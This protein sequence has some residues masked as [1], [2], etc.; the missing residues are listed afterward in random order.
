MTRL[1][2]PG[3]ALFSG[4]GLFFAQSTGDVQS[5]HQGNAI[6]SVVDKT[7][8]P[9]PVIPIVQWIFQQPPWVMWGG[10]VL[11]A[12]LAFFILRWFWRRRRN[13]LGWLATR[14][15]IAKLALAG[16]AAA[17]V[18]ALAG[19]GFKAYDFVENDNRFCN[20]CH[21]F[22]PSG[23]AWILPDTGH[24]TLVNRMEGK[25][26][27][28]SCHACHA[29][30]PTKE[31]VKLVFWMSGAR[32]EQIPPHAKVPREV[33]EDC[34]VQGDAKETW[35]QI[36]RT[37]GHRTHLESDSAALVGKVECL[38]CHA[39]SAHR[40]QPPDSTCAQDGCHLTGEI[41]IKLGKMGGQADLHCS[42]CH[43]F[44]RD[45]PA[46]ATRDSAAGT[47]R[48]GSKEC[49]SCHAMRQQLAEFDP[50]A[51]PHG[52]TCGMCHNPHAQVKPADAL[53]SCAAAQC[54]ADWRS[55][56]FHLGLRHRKVAESCTTCHLPHRAKVD[57]SDCTGCHESLQT[58]RSR[59][60]RLNLPQPFDTTRALERTSLW[61]PAPDKVKPRPGKGDGLS[62]PDPL[63]AEDDRLSASPPDSFSHARHRQLACLTCHTTRTGHGQLTFQSP[64]GCQI[65][66]HQAPARS[67]C[68]SCHPA[69]EL[70]DPLPV[71]VRVAVTP[72]PARPRQVSFEHS[73]HR[74]LPCIECHTAPVSLEPS[75]PVGT[76]A[77]CHAEHHEAT[78]NCASCHRTGTITEP[79]ARPVEAHI[80]CDACHALA[81]VAKLSPSRPFCLTCHSTEQDHYESRE[82]TTCH[83]Q[84]RPEEFRAHLL[85]V[86]E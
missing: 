40:F 68:S 78:R 33:C 17:V 22:V 83:F 25:H 15:R 32:Q 79:H 35:Q 65:C 38:T 75:A 11:A 50:G 18:V 53:K 52:G 9:D 49:F 28:L 44:T 13:V 26:D 58:R 57:A 82:C 72:N 61:E 36:A 59:G 2:G 84:A 37:A 81:T 60:P 51:D 69:T 24:Y 74:S 62:P 64:R 20:G 41:Q 73:A 5:L 46:L 7:I 14:N 67:D 10:V 43:Q 16:A 86:G 34:H 29:L 8:L 19:V 77:A 63:A 45:V 6:D 71:E 76:C 31:A 54:H 3:N 23:Q 55:E 48:P 80:G 27:T 66:H 47:L 21:I 70:Q 39:L 30:N 4:L 56:P 85:E 12:I 1:S 42:V